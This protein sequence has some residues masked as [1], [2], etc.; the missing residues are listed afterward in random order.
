MAKITYT[1]TAFE[2]SDEKMVV[3]VT[4]YRGESALLSADLMADDYGEQVK[5]YIELYSWAYETDPSDVW[6][7]IDKFRTV[8]RHFF[9]ATRTKTKVK[10]LRAEYSFVRH[11]DGVLCSA[12][13][14]LPG[15]LPAMKY[16]KREKFEIHECSS[17]RRTHTKIGLS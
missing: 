7:A 11:K 14:M 9:N 10:E 2:D 17:P 13:G 12:E 6:R 1:V 3:Q 4:A 16:V 8:Y 15:F 5:H